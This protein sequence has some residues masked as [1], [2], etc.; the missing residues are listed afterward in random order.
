MMIH[1]E[2]NTI[3]EQTKYSKRSLNTTYIKSGFRDKNTG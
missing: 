1:H 3:K 2:M